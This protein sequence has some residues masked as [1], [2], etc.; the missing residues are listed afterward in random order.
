MDDMELSGEELHQTLSGLSVI[1]KLLGNTSTT[2]SEV[3]TEIIK[4]NSPLKIIDLGCGSGDNLRAI[5]KWCSTNE[6]TVEL[7]GI[8]GNQNILDYARVQGTS[9]T[10]IQYVQADILADDFLLP[11]C[12]ILISSHF[13]YHF[14]DEAIVDFLRK[15]T[16]QVSTAIIFSELQRSRLA[17][18][19][20]KLGGP[21]LP[22]TQMVK[23]D[24]LLAIS[25]S[26]TRSELSNLLSRA[27]IENY[28]ISWRWAFRYLVSVELMR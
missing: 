2:L 28:K 16:S 22:F 27:G 5:A 17:Y 3:I 11:E 13:M 20:F 26:F 4:K 6:K 15:A 19:L 9:S 21:L 23:E 12:D 18:F 10:H 7:I 1:N 25:R 14:S 8:D 24:G